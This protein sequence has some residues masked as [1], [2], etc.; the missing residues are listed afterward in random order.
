LIVV[1]ARRNDHLMPHLLTARSWHGTGAWLTQLSLGIIFVGVDGTGLCSCFRGGTL[2][3]DG[4]MSPSS[5]NALGSSKQHPLAL[6]SGNV[7]AVA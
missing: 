2:G 3:M 6:C 7:F 4:N 1:I 5:I